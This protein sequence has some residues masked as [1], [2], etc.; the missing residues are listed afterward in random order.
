MFHLKRGPLLNALSFNTNKL[1]INNLRRLWLSQSPCLLPFE[2]E[3]F[4]LAYTH[5]AY[6][7]VPSVIQSTNDIR[8]QF[9]NNTQ[10]KNKSFHRRLKKY[11]KLKINHSIIFLITINYRLRCRHR[12]NFRCSNLPLRSPEMSFCA[13]QTTP[14]IRNPQLL[15]EYCA[16]CTGTRFRAPTVALPIRC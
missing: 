4:C 6:T 1:L 12:R 7:A 5:S 10:T 2:K 16:L 3:C 14:R 13:S 8:A 15:P 9:E 11:K